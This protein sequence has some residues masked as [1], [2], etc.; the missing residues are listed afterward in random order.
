MVDLR[1]AREGI[2]LSLDEAARQACELGVPIDPAK[3]GR[4]ENGDIRVER[5][6]LRLAGLAAVYGVKL[7]EIIPSDQREDARRFVTMFRDKPI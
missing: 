6:L 3:I 5:D 7:R 4:L 1:K 2:G